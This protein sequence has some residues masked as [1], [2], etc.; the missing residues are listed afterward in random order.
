MS[1]ISFL[2]QSLGL[3]TS[4]NLWDAKFIIFELVTVEKQSDEKIHK[5]KILGKIDH[6]VYDFE[7]ETHDF[8]CG[9]PLIVHN[10]DSSVLSVSKKGIIRDLKNLEDIIDFNNLNENH[11]FFSNNKKNW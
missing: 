8:N 7:T 10:T 2:C 11:D 6:Y 9:F 4:K 1:S 3:Q 5:P